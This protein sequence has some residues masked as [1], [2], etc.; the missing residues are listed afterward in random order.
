MGIVHFRDY[1]KIEREARKKKVPENTQM[2]EVEAFSYQNTDSYSQLLQQVNEVFWEKVLRN[3][4]DNEANKGNEN[5]HLFL[6]HVESLVRRGIGFSISTVG[7]NIDTNPIPFV[8]WS[9]PHERKRSFLEE[10]ELDDKEDEMLINNDS[11]ERHNSI[12]LWSNIA[13]GMFIDRSGLSVYDTLAFIDTKETLIENFKP[14]ILFKDN[15]NEMTF[16]FDLNEIENFLEN[17][18]FLDDNEYYFYD[19]PFQ[20]GKNGNSIHALNT[21][22]LYSI[23]EYLLLSNE[24]QDVSTISPEAFVDIEGYLS[25]EIEYHLSLQSNLHIIDE[26]SEFVKSIINQVESAVIVYLSDKVDFDSKIELAD[27]DIDTSNT[28]FKIK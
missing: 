7:G 5:P 17:N 26:G 2:K 20:M 27:N 19:T 16:K 6:S 25:E 24:N 1:D 10:E 9:A 23:N 22:I 8:G 12:K 21:Q 11:F 28:R 15:D 14:V 18:V 4:A 13:K 3:W